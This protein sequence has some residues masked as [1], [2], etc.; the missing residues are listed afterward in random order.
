MDIRRLKEKRSLDSYSPIRY[1][2]CMKIKKISNPRVERTFS[3]EISSKHHNYSI[4]GLVSK[5][6]HGV[7]YS[8]IIFRCLYL[9]AHYT[10]EWWAA[11]LSLC[12]PKK[13]ARY[14]GI[15]KSEGVEFGSLDAKNLTQLFSVVDNKIVP[16]L[17]SIDKIGKSTS[18]KYVS[19]NVD[20]DGFDDFVGKFGSS[21]IILERLIKL[22]AFDE[23]NRN[24]KGLWKWFLFK[25]TKD[26]DIVEEVMPHFEWSEEDIQKE[27]DRQA[28]EYF[29]FYPKRK[30]IPSKISNWKP[31]IGRRYE[32]PTMDQVVSLFDDFTDAEK[33]GF[34]KEYFGSYWNNPLSL[35]ETSE[36]NVL[37]IGD[38]CVADVVIEDITERTT[39]TGGLFRSLRVTDGVS[40]VDVAVWE[41]DFLNNDIGVFRTGNGINIE[42]LWKEKFRS[43][44]MAPGSAV[45]SL[46]R[47]DA[48]R[49]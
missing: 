10:S 37:K 42:L 15:A 20:F 13:Q 26:R 48:N 18:Q 16:G 46:E 4:H 32:T 31:K 33:L 8:L 19:R 25:H 38:D 39:K 12:H 29:K 27:K 24:R 35:Y 22:G 36:E 34:E 5:N 44:N 41:D 43:F 17:E 1:F 47:K 3:P 21:K 9:K 40:T 49:G 2:I 11:V 7:G 28:K 30:K 6:S 14:I 23:I 45:H